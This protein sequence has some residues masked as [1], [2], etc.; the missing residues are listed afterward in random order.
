[1]EAT[2]IIVRED[3]QVDPVTIVAEGLLVGRLPTCELLLNHPSVSRLHAGITSAEGDFYIRN[4]RPGN[5]IML[6][7]ERLEEY[8]ALADGDVI[9]I[10]PF[11]LNIHFLQGNLVIKTSLQIA[12]T[13]RDAVMRKDDSGLWDMPTTVKLEL[14]STPPEGESA[15][16]A[17]K[18]PAPRRAKPAGSSSKA[19]D[20]FWDKRITSATKTIKPSPLFPLTGRPSGK[21]QS[22]WAPTTDLRRRWPA[23]MLLWGA[24]PVVLLAGAS[25]L[26]YASAFSPAPISDAHTRAGMILLPAVATHANNGSCTSCHGLTSN[27][28]ARCASCHTTDA[29]VA[30]V[31]HPHMNAGI[32]CMACHSEHRGVEFSA[33]A[34]ALQSCSECHNDKNKKLY[35]GKSV[36]TP[37]GGTFGYPVIN[38]QW[39]WAGLDPEELLQRK[40][41][42]KLER[43]PSDSEDQWRSKQFH[44]IHMY[45]VR[46]VAGLAGNKDGELSCSSCHNS[47]A[48]P[49]LATPRTTCA[50][51]HNGERDPRAGRQVIASNQPNCTSCH[52]QHRLDKRHWN[53][54]LLVRR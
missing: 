48:P 25:A 24:I 11:A 54:S 6:N 51:C 23:S 15:E 22:V 41:T 38:G 47:F 10:G 49:D 53:P 3:L 33:I 29:F 45:R 37:H 20:V 8:E 39:K 16:A 31:I 14:P 12:A 19:L 34:G 4:L 7:G 1:M 35:N 26:F 2:F 9:G 32:G 27:M 17:H 43:L 52:I 50:K 40:T 44:G 30:T 21:A 36:S 46:A 42:L 28:E 5:P 18:K 13:A